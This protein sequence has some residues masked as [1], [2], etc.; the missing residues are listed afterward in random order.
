MGIS[1]LLAKFLQTDNLKLSQNKIM[2]TLKT[3]VLGLLSRAKELAPED[4]FNH[5]LILLGKTVSHGSIR[6]YNRAG[7]SKERLDAIQ[8]DL[9]KASNVTDVEISNYNIGV[10]VEGDDMVT[11]LTGNSLDNLLV[12]VPSEEFLQAQKKLVEAGETTQKG[13]K[14][15]ALYPFL[16]DVDCPDE[17]KVLVADMMKAYR[18]FTTGHKEASDLIYG[19][20]END[21]EPQELNA[22]M[23]LALGEGLI[24]DWQL[25]ELIHKELTYYAEHKKVLGDHPKLQTLALVQK[26]DAMGVKAVN[27]R[28]RQLEVNLT[29]NGDKL[30]SAKDAESKDEIQ[31][32]IDLY[33]EEKALVEARIAALNE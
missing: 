8:Y 14:L 19:D 29:N 4:L 27:K 25:N 30:K 5:C 11:R 16:D 33:T 32:R 17:L 22:E 3:K 13:F 18:D 7:Y 20:P 31:S 24:K 9:K 10:D 2:N 15:I 21:K 28:L 12:P 26:V 6:Y 1:A 23:L